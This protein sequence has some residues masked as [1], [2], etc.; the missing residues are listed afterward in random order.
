MMLSIGTL[1]ASGAQPVLLFSLPPH[2]EF[3]LM[4]EAIKL[5]IFQILFQNSLRP[6]HTHI[7]SEYLVPS[8]FSFFNY[9]SSITFILDLD[10]ADVLNSI[11]YDEGSYSP[12]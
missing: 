6:H 12:S 1:A 2:A 11:L 8:L 10:S 4:L 9:S 3:P 5:F 7:K